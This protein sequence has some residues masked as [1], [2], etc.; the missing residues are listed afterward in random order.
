V[1]AEH[2]HDATLPALGERRRRRSPFRECGGLVFVA[3]PKLG[4]RLQ[5]THTAWQQLGSTLPTENRPLAQ[6]WLN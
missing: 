2:Q 5:R 4:D 1:K 3:D 6:L